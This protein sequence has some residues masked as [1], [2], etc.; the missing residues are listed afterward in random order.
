MSSVFLQSLLTNYIPCPMGAAIAHYNQGL[1]RYYRFFAGV[2]LQ[3]DVA[4][5]QVPRLRRYVV[6]LERLGD[7]H[8]F[9][10]GLAPYTGACARH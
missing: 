10:G 4:A 3:G 6:S 2:L 9:L 1:A 5:L 8:R 7:N